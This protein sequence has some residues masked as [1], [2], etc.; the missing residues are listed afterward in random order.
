MKLGVVPPL[1]SSK[2]MTFSSSFNHSRFIAPKHN[3]NKAA[4]TLTAVHC[5]ANSSRNNHAARLPL[6]QRR[7]WLRGPSH[8][9]T[10]QRASGFSHG[11]VTS[12]RMQATS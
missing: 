9:T 5:C 10:A 1:C 2:L 6:S 12:Y 7:L 11:S 4:R 8:Q 3:G